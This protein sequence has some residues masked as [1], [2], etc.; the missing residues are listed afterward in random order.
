MCGFAGIINNSGSLNGIQ[1]SGIA[2]K[3]KFRGPDSCGV[4]IYNSEW[5]HAAQG[6]HALFFNRLAIIDLDP[7]SDQPF[8]DEEYVLLFNGEIYNYRELRSELIATGC[9]FTTTSDTEVLF[10]AL[11]EW[12]KAALKRLNGM[13]AFSW[14]S[15]KSNT[16]ILA[17]D[18]VGIKPLYYSQHQQSFSFGSELHSILRLS[19]KTPQ[20]S[21]A[22]VQM[23]LWMQFVPTPYSIIEGV[24]KLPPGNYI[25][26]TIRDLKKGIVLQPKTYW[27]AYEDIQTNDCSSVS[28]LEN[29][30]KNS[31]ERQLHA[32]VPLGLFLSSGVDS[33]LLAALVNKYFAKDQ[34]VNFFTVAFSE[35]TDSDES[36][37]A[38]SFI[39]GFNNP[40][41]HSHKL[42]VDA[43]YIQDHLQELY[44][45]YDEPFGDYAA[46]LNWVISKK[47]REYVTVAISGDGSDELFWG[48]QRYN[49]WQKLRQINSVPLL[50][51][52]VRAFAHALPTSSFR[53]KLLTRF[54]RN[55]VQRH[56]DLFLL[57][58]IKANVKD[59]ILGNSLWALDGVE[60][61]AAREDLP[62]ILDMKTYLSDAM[63]YKV[64]RA[65]MASS[66]EV[67]VP[68]LDNEVVDFALNL[69]YKDKS[70][71][72]YQNKALLKILLQ[73]L[74]PHYNINK[75]KRGFNFPLKEWLKT[76]WKDEVYAG[77]T[78][79][80]L[81]DLGLDAKR[82]LSI[83]NDFYYKNAS[84]EIDVWY[85]Y[86]LA[87]WKKSFDKL[88]NESL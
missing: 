15:K 76:K 71:N 33:S 69:P 17:R 62:G 13:F 31:L 25:E 20:V 28:D 51:P 54:Q 64:D 22:A 32:D 1:V 37:D 21:H 29:V 66:L 46:V 82:Y 88:K 7:R 24:Y 23:Y 38:I 47:A 70:N 43:S 84:Y 27:N 41:L 53:K 26:G 75:P 36:A 9:E 10:R 77:V 61:I 86:N 83:I 80:L 48:Y 34:D 3:V 49:R 65:S 14:I 19:G 63:L 39:Q 57:E 56:F 73:Q 45:Y 16:F 72:Q 6:P 8:E 44:N 30:L 81:Q 74:A 55:N 79:P 85:L 18:R 12:G 60:S 67:R 11:K 4:R 87:L 40:K 35:L 52:A 58:G 2:S 5:Q 50:T 78:T 42:S 59:S 68:F